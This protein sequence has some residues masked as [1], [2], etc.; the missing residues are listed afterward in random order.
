MRCHVDQKNELRS[1]DTSP[2]VA[3]N[4]AMVSIEDCA[5]I[6]GKIVDTME[7]KYVLGTEYP[8]IPCSLHGVW[9]VPTERAEIARKTEY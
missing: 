1:S 5:T 8:S 2:I 4:L 9:R 6:E 7:C 3:C